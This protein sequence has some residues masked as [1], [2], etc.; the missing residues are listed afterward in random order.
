MGVMRSDPRAR[1]IRIASAIALLALLT[2]CAPG[3]WYQPRSPI[4]TLAPSEQCPVQLDNARDVP[5]RSDGSA[6]LLPA[7]SRPTSALLCFYGTPPEGLGKSAASP[8]DIARQLLLGSSDAAELSRVIQ[9]L[10]LKAPPAGVVNCP[11]DSGSSAILDFRFAKGRDAELRWKTDGCQQLDNG[12]L[13]ATQ[14]ANDS[15]GT[16]QDAVAR[17]AR[18]AG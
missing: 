12:R 5:D 13:A 17:L 7:G 15:F 8:G 3:T 16:F 14:L 10:D 2:G 18:A 1:A 11:M 9:S 6:T 4:V